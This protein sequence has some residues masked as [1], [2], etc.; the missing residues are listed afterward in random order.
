MDKY[1]YIHHEPFEFEA[2]GTLD[3]LKIVYHTSSP[4]KTDQQGKLKPVIWICH[5]LTA[6]SDAEDWW[7]QLVGPGKL[8]DTEKYYIVCVNMLGSPYG[9]SSPSTT[10]PETGQPFYFDFPRITVR[11]IVKANI[12]VRQHLGLEHIDL[13]IGSSIGGFQAVEW[14]VMEPERIRKAVLMATSCRT[15]PWL[16][17]WDEAMRMALEADPSFRA[18]ADLNGGAAALRAARA[19]GMLSYRSYEGY[20][21]TQAEPDPDVI[22]PDRAASYQRY[23][24]KKFS[25]RFDAYSYFYLCY[26]ADS[27]NVGRKRGGCEAALARVQAD[28]TVIGIDSDRIL[29]LEE[30]R[31]LAEHIP[32][33]RFHQI[34]SR[35]GH[36]GFLLESDQITAIVEP[37]L[38]LIELCK[39]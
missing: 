1:E 32:G 21:L 37:L 31:F 11:D 12:L 13:I 22:F 4:C 3:D 38:N 2:G 29:P 8:F 7:P 25:D 16:L 10:N 23:Q 5:A 30:Q 20:N 27:N 19:I 36:D 14:L 33:A 34:S 28:C 35:F 26:S 17:A 6:N 24:G 18:C 39:Y 9:S 15:T